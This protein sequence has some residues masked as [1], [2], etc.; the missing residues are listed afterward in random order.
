MKATLSSP[1]LQTHLAELDVDSE[2]AEFNV[3][4]NTQ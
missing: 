2:W 1:Q 3:P 4:L